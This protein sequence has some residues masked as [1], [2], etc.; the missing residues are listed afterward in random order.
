MNL[1]GHD[2]PVTNAD[3]ELDGI[4][5]TY[6]RQ[7]FPDDA[8]VS[9][10]NLDSQNLSASP[11][12]WFVDPI[13]GTKDYA[14]GHGEWSVMIGLCID[15]IPTLGVVYQPKRD[16]LWR[17][18]VAQMK[19]E[20]IR[21]SKTTV[22]H[23]KPEDFNPNTFTVVLSH[24]ASGYWT[25]KV[26]DYLGAKKALHRSSV[27]LKLAAIASG[28]ADLYITNTGRIKVWDTCGPAAILTAAG[29][30]ISGTDGNPLRYDQEV[31]HGV[32]LLAGVPGAF[33]KFNLASAGFPPPRR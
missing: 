21:G 9:E 7:E 28:E 32:A 13:D 14:R 6:L 33:R 29:G 31:A 22:L 15:G 26:L 5:C 23:R 4:I 20:Q 18:D 12:V 27:G 1:K 17:G 30:Q 24:R 3:I 8:I 25:Q 10:E 2:D 11:R 19:C 16:V